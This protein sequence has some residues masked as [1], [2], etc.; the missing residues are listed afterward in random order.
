MPEAFFLSYEELDWCNE[1]KQA[2]LDLYLFAATGASHIVSMPMK[3][4]LTKSCYMTLIGFSSNF[5]KTSIRELPTQIWIQAL[6]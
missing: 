1:M 6:K 2:G 5:K 4:S 3:N